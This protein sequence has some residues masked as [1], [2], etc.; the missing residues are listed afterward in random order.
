MEVLLLS[1]FILWIGFSVI[2]AA[3]ASK[4]GRSGVGW[5]F[6]GLLISP[7]LATILVL[8]VKDLSKKLCDAC[9]QQIPI[10]AQVCPYCKTDLAA[11]L[12]PA[13]G[14]EFTLE[15]ITKKCPACAETIKLEALVCRFCGQKFDPGE[16]QAV[17]QQAKAE[18]EQQK[19][20][21]TPEKKNKLDRG[22]CPNC[23]AYQAFKIDA[24]RNLRTCE[25]CGE[26][27]PLVL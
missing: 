26:Q 13:F 15:T 4:R 1:P 22:L 21:L 10:P 3:I 24:S 27:Y 2:P 9:G 7:L 17:I 25:V 11:K 6:L 16:V 8:A 20:V 14:R 19:T 18:W 5:F 23:D 12:G